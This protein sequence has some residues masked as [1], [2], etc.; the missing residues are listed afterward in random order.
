MR[1]FS[2]TTAVLFL[3][4]LVPVIAFGQASLKGTVTDAATNE[5]LI[6]V[7]VILQGTSLGT[8]TN[9]EGQFRIVGIPEQLF[10]IRV[11]YVGYEPQLIETDFSKTKDV[12][13]NL[14]MKPTVIEGKEVLVTAQ[15]RGQI[16]AI[17]Q[18]LTSNAIIN[19]VSEEKIKELPDAN[20]AEAI[21]RLPGVSLTRNGGEATGVVL[22]GLSSKF[23]N[24]TVDGVKIPATDP[25]TRDV[26]LSTISQGALAGIELY[27]TLLPDMDAD[28]IAGAINLVTRKAPSERVI[29]FDLTGDYNNLMKSANQYDFQGRYGERFY[30]DKLGIQLQG[31]IEKR[32][33][34]KENTAM[35]WQ[36]QKSTA[37]ASDSL[38]GKYSIYNDYVTPGYGTATFTDET[39]DRNGIQSILDFNTPDSGSVKLSGLYSETGRDIATHSRVYVG[40]SSSA[41]WDYNYEY[42]E[43]R[44]STVNAS[45]QGK[46]YLLGLDIDWCASYAKSVTDNPYDFALKFTGGGADPT[47][48]I[49]NTLESLSA[50]ADNN[51]AAAQCSTGVY[52]QQL[53]FDQDKTAYVNALKK[54]T[55]GTTMSGAV[56]IGGKYREK[57]RWMTAEEYD[58]N[59]YLGGYLYHNGI[60]TVALKNSRFSSYFNSS[61]PDVLTDFIDSPVGSRGLLG[62]FA[63][64]PLI[65]LDALKQWYSL[66]KDANNSGN[67]EFVY[68]QAGRLTD[69]TVVERVSSEYLMNTLNFGQFATLIAG[70]RVETE[71]NDYI[72]KYCT[73]S[74]GTI[75]IAVT[76]SKPILDSVAMFS[77]TSWLPNLQFTIKPTSYLNIRLA[78]YKAIAR[79]D[80]NLRLPQY[81]DIGQSGGIARVTSGNIN[82]KNMEA[83][84]YEANAQVYDNTIGLVSLS[85]FYKRITNYINVTNN[86]NLEPGIFKQLCA[87]YNM[88]F[89]DQSIITDFSGSNGVKANIPYNDPDP[90]Y[91]WGLELEHQMNFGFLPGYLKNITLSYNISI[92]RSLTHIIYGVTDVAIKRDS[93]VNRIT[94]VVTYSYSPAYTRDY[95]VITRES[96]GQPNL[97][98]NAALGYDIG[99]FSGRL[100]VF[101]QDKYVRQYTAYDQANIIQDPFFKMDLSLKQQITNSI[102]IILNINNV[103]NRSETR[104]EENTFSSLGIQ[105]WSNPSTEE[106][107]GRTIDLGVR[108]SL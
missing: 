74:L 20:A 44:I 76:A 57:T 13:L 105:P 82:L 102:A 68:S 37:F 38:R 81:S 87:Q 91:V 56:K 26:D 62:K 101:Y 53:N 31:N 85:A 28:A 4:L 24:I 52:K 84:N 47:Q 55:I 39:R 72:A 34:S 50:R 9:I 77:Q 21:G 6:G 5:T 69:Y 51:F 88:V 80:Y 23:S 14:Q 30:D 27:K 95:K 46:N 17:N 49:G 36:Q 33:R 2:F 89:T 59:N 83:W 70:V 48:S 73:G 19:V 1:V 25:N 63:F 32:I 12:S 64:T 45:L 11:S 42:N 54:Y 79:P 75:G 93:T 86:I 108:I 15:M 18:Q 66:F 99:G 106:L 71:N 10:T 104:T 90:S 103:T 100:S 60:D 94:H 43:L 29:R 22:R 58:D 7:N 41:Y 65:N 78:A 40:T 61:V 96:E 98:G 107:Y 35:N 16:A 8:A 67:R 3:S 92:T 97:Y